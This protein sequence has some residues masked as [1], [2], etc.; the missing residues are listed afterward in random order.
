MDVRGSGLLAAGILVMNVAT[1]GFQI[2]AA[3]ILGPATY[4]AVGAMLALQLVIAV[5]QL[6]V[7]A[8]A[9][10][11]VAAAPGDVRSIER[12]MK[13]VTNRAAIALT[14]LMIALSPVIQHGLRLPSIWTALIVGVAAYPITLWGGQAGI[15]QGE[16]R[17]RD[18]ALLYLANGVPRVVI[19]PLFML[20]HPTE[21]SA[22]LAVLIAQ[23]SPAIVG[24]WVLR[25]PHVHE[26]HPDVRGA[27]SEMLHGSFA[28]LGFVALSN[29]DIL[30]A[31]HIL[32][33]NS[34]QAGL[35]AAG[36]IVTKVVLFLPQS[37]IVLVFPSMSKSESRRKA[38]LLSLSVVG[39]LGV[40]G[41]AGSWILS[42]L[43]LVFVGGHDYQGVQHDLWRFAVLGTALSVLQLLV[44]SVLARQHRMSSVLIWLAFGAVVVFGLRQSSLTGLVTVVTI[45]DSILMALLLSHSLWETRH[46]PAS[47]PAHA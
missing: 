10:R 39:I 27:V 38:L 22:M 11:R 5:V 42:G 41:I 3:T 4:S 9:A 44:Y 20:V 23:F 15:L 46:A 33:H 25:E 8:T 6:G 14:V 32:P 40:V 45:I 43:A 34:I 1:F 12:T 19:G 13:V 26:P 2:L 24:W 29:V 36:L 31:R 16:R 17:W 47:E 35:Y 30:I 21:T 18:L 37:V 7:Q 28:M